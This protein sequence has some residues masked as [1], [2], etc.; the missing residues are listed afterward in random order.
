MTQKI[1]RGFR[2][3]ASS[4]L[5]LGRDTLKYGSADAGVTVHA[6]IPDLNEQM[7]RAAAYLNLAGHLVGRKDPKVIHSCGD[8]EA[9]LGL[10]RTNHVVHRYY[11]RCGS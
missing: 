2:L 6:D 11:R 8:I 7:Q 9:H 1:F 10:V 3:I 5:P 4:W